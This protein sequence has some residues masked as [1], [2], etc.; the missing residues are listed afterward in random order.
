MKKILHKILNKKRR[1]TAGQDNPAD[2]LRITNETVAEH[3]E[4]V[5]ATG[6]KFKYPLHYPRHRIVAITIGL[7]LLLVVG[8]SGLITWSLYVAQDTNDLVYSVT[9]ILPLPVAEVDGQIVRY[10]DYLVQLRSALYYLSTKEAVNFSSDDGKRQL[11]YQRRLALNK[12][13]SD[14]YVQQIAKQKNITVT[15]KELDDFITKQIK[16]SQLGVSQ[17]AYEQVIKD[18]YNWT[19]DDYRSSVRKELLKVKVM[20]AIDTTGQ[21]TINQILQQLN[22]GK[23]FAQLAKADSEDI[24]SKLNGGDVGVVTTSTDDPSGLIKAAKQLQI[25][26]TSGVIDGIDGFYIVKLLDRHD[27]QLH[28]AKIFIAYKTFDSQLASLKRVGKIKEFIKVSDTG[29]IVTQTG[30]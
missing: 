4:R 11:D 7:V 16:D 24:T 18:Y 10:N 1:S 5:L 12:A 25:G 29:T 20:A 2:S 6:R 17:Q 13:I 27:D 3:R 30:Q 26:Q 19:F 23:D 21:Q 28:L 14:G 8:L 22:Q 9:Q 15:S